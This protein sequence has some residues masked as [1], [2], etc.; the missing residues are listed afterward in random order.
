M[1]RGA[2]APD[3][4]PSADAASNGITAGLRRDHFALLAPL[5]SDFGP[6]LRPS[7]F[8]TAQVQKQ[9]DALAPGARV[10]VLGLTPETIACRWRSETQLQ[11]IDHSPAVMAM[12][13]PNPGAPPGAQAV[14]GSWEHL[15]FPDASVD[16]VCGDGCQIGLRWPDGYE[17]FH[18]EVRRVLKPSGRFLTRVFMRPETKEPLSDIQRDFS[19]GHIGSVHV[20]KLRILAALQA[21]G[22]PGGTRLDDAW[23]V[24]STFASE[25]ER[26]HRP[27][28]TRREIGTIDRYRGVQTRFFL[29]TLAEFRSATHPCYIEESCVTGSY[30]LAERCP[31]LVM[32]PRQ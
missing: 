32:T 29:P 18:R 19:H 27:G 28:W 15:P 26:K 9:A 3:R 30:E 8:D 20:L 22:G 31:T 2:A 6:P 5:W 16:L 25:A 21:A 14:L 12:L 11:A 24:W 23:Q 7:A 10:L 13:W 17:T 1:S 4:E